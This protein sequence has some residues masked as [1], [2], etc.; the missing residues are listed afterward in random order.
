MHTQRA[1]DMPGPSLLD[2]LPH[3][4]VIAAIEQ[5]LGLVA[6][7]L[8]D[9][10]LAA[11]VDN[12]SVDFH[13]HQSIA[14]YL[15]PTERAQGRGYDVTTSAIT[16]QSSAEALFFQGDFSASPLKA[17]LQAS[18]P[19]I[20]SGARVARPLSGHHRMKTL[21]LLRAAGLDPVTFESLG[22]GNARAN[23]TSRSR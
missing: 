8:L 2:G 17:R 9:H 13:L 21:A 1:S 15:T 5:R 16:L 10:P 6:A 3:P 14:P 23:R 7:A 18:A 12:L 11:R 20:F 22:D 4:Q 19:C